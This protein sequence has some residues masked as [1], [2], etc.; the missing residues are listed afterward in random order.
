MKVTSLL[1]NPYA[2]ALAFAATTGACA[3]PPQAEDSIA[4]ST[5]AL[6]ADE[7]A[8]QRDACFKANPIL[9][10][11][12]CPAQYAQCTRTASDGLPAQVSSAITD[13]EECI[14]EARSCVLEASGAT[15]AA[16]CAADEAQCVAAIVGAHLPKVVEGTAACVD[17]TVECIRSSEVVS[18]LAGCAGTLE[19]CAVEQIQAVLPPE[20]V[21]VVS[22]VTSC[23]TALNGCIAE[24]TRPSALTACTETEAKCIAQSLGVTLPDVPVAKVVD[25]AQTAAECTLDASSASDVTA[26]AR[27]LTSCAAAAVGVGGDPKPQTCEQ[28]FTTCMGRNPLNF[29]KCGA[30]LS[31]CTN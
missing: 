5:A 3:A 18:D 13:A 26:C 24:A 21:K 1:S 20:V 17:S 6:T 29:L 16:R 19:S 4:E 14:K 9:G 25:C 7:C 11:L 12:T 8:S 30:E 28:K 15:G 22:D 27:G 31:G 10:L 23:T 2:Y